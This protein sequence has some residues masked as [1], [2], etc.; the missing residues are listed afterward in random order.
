MEIEGIKV[1]QTSF[2]NKKR[3]LILHGWQGSPSPHWQTFLQA[4]LLTNNYEVSFPMLPNKDNPDLDL[5][6]MTLDFQI[7]TFKP[8]III[9]HSLANILWF[10]YVNQNKMTYE[11]EKLMLVSPVS[12]LC[13]IEELKS[14]FPYQV[15]NDLK[16]K[17]KIMASSDNDP[18]ITIDELY[19]LS[20][21][22]SI[23]LKIIEGA[24][25]I[26]TESGYGKLSCAYDWISS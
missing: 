23:G 24:G 1:Q 7:Q 5:W 4:Q 8:E 16:A 25:H 9:C 2:A 20:N 13:K 3:V 15:P 17:N 19:E 22:L 26:N 10:H 14:F 6:L 21:H 18:Y 11:L 12:P